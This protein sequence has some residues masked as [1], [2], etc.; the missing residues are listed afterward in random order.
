MKNA[1]DGLFGD[2]FERLAIVHVPGEDRLDFFEHLDDAVME[3][4]FVP[5]KGA[6]GKTEKNKEEER[7]LFQVN[8]SK[9]MRSLGM[10]I[11]SRA[12]LS[13]WHI[14]TNPQP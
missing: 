5:G 6:A 1:L 2:F 14:G 7:G 9:W 4:L 8:C 11:S 12:A 10:P 3:R 13:C